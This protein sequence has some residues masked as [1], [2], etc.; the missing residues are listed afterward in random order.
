MLTSANL[1]R[2]KSVVPGYVWQRRPFKLDLRELEQMFKSQTGVLLVV[3]PDVQ[4][5]EYALALMGAY[6]KRYDYHALIGWHSFFER[7]VNEYT[8]ALRLPSLKPVTLFSA[9]AE[10][11]DLAADQLHD[12]IAL[13]KLAIIGLG[14]QDVPKVSI[15][16]QVFNVVLSKKTINI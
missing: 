5:R 16:H 12:M 8:G 6:V 7:E 10:L 1:A 2:M 15:S 4:I 14:P 9:K 3:N 13:C 11:T